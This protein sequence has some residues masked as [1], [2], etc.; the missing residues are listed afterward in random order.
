[1]IL[2]IDAALLGPVWHVV[3]IACSVPQ[4]PAVQDGPQLLPFYCLSTLLEELKDQ[5]H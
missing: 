3:L 2:H 4:D 1:M 5:E